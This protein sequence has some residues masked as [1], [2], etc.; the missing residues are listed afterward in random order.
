MI[1]IALENQLECQRHYGVATKADV[2]CRAFLGR[3]TLVGKA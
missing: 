2:R 1:A 3:P